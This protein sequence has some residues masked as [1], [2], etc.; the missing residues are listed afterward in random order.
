VTSVI[1]VVCKQITANATVFQRISVLFIILVILIFENNLYKIICN[2]MKDEKLYIYIY[3]YIE[4]ERERERERE[5]SS[6]LFL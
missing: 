3:I 4:R 2:V 5:L 1:T 6:N